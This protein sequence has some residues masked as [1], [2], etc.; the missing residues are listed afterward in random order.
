MR[1]AA[2]LT[3]ALPITLAAVPSRAA[4]PLAW[5]SVAAPLAGPARVIGRYDAS[6]IAGA[7]SA[8][9][10]GP[11]YQ[12]LDPARHRFYGHPDLVGFV[13][14]LGRSAAGAHLGTVAVGDMAQPRGGPMSSGHVSHQGGLDVDVWFRLDLPPLPAAA[15]D[16]IPQPS[17]VD[18][19]TGRPD[20]ARWSQ[21]NAELVH[22]AA[23]D[24]RVSRVFVGAAIKRDLCQRVW[25]DRSWL[26]I[27]R[28]W[29]GHDDH[30]HVRL[31][32]PA[33]SP[34]CVS[35]PAPPPGDGC[36]APELAAA[37]AR[38]R[39]ERLRPPPVPHGV[40]PPACTALV[41]R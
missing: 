2:L 1:F 24:P 7:V 6:C 36:S 12:I 13:G 35:Q 26:Q 22:L 8:P 4:P 5:A 16:G 31:R 39:A 21:R 10:E 33:G 38:E 23:L 14:D 18:E 28:P 3:A 9:L 29:P 27:V 40:L 25:P 11:G 20:P 37:F 34:A 32:C 19:K 41:S 30:L 15:R 17:L